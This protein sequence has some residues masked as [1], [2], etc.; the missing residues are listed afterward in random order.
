MRSRAHDPGGIEPLESTS[1]RSARALRSAKPHAEALAHRSAPAHRHR[2]RLLR[3]D[4]APRAPLA[5]QLTQ[6]LGDDEIARLFD[7]TR[8]MLARLDRSP[9]RARRAAVPGEGHR[10]PSRDGRARPLP[11][12]VSRVRLARAAHRP[13]R[14]RDE[15][16]RALPD[17][18]PAARR[19]RALA[20]A[21]RRLAR[22]LEELEERRPAH[23]AAP[24]P[25]PASRPD[26]ADRPPPRPI[27]RR[28]RG[29]APV[30]ASDRMPTRNRDW[31]GFR[32]SPTTPPSATL[33]RPRSGSPRPPRPDPAPARPLRV[34]ARP[35]SRQ[36]R[37][38]GAGRA[39]GDT[40]RPSR[41]A[42]RR[43]QRRSCPTGTATPSCRPAGPAR[44]CEPRCR[45]RARPGAG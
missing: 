11:R 8:A 45:G 6:Q 33:G 25:L 13:R 28:S 40:A 16:L 35:L 23:A 31:T 34:R 32:S 29:S 5:G 2:Q 26:A 12:A 15:L 44:S 27:A 22:T 19:P 3:R 41:G 43:G 37:V 9:A 18:R 36:T 4:P 10:V 42:G 14:E 7:A 24:P 21:P 20:P 39:R 38:R 1:R 17:R 30:P